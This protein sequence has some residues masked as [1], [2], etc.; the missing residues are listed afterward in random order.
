MAWLKGFAGR[1]EN[2]LNQLDQGAATV[3]NNNHA[4]QRS[5]NSFVGGAAETESESRS[6]EQYITGTR[7]DIVEEKCGLIGGLKQSGRSASQTKTKKDKQAEE[8]QLIKFLN[9]SEDSGVA[10]MEVRGTGH[11]LDWRKENIPRPD[12]NRSF[13]PGGL[14]DLSGSVLMETDSSEPWGDSSCNSGRESSASLEGVP[15]EGLQEDMALN[16][17]HSTDGGCDNLVT[18]KL[19]LATQNQMLRQEISSLTQETSRVLARAKQ[20]EKDVQSLRVS[21]ETE[22]RNTRKQA[23]TIRNLEEKSGRAEITFHQEVEK[24][25]KLINEKDQENLALQGQLSA[26]LA[27]N[28]RHLSQSQEVAGVQSQAILAMEERMRGSEE[29]AREREAMV[30]DERISRR[31]LEINLTEKIKGLEAERQNAKRELISVQK[32]QDDLKNTIGELQQTLATSKAECVDAQKELLEYRAKAQRILLEKENFILQLKEGIC[33]E[34]ED[35]VQ[36]IELQQITKE[37]NLFCEEATRF[38]DQLSSTRRELM[39]MEQ[40]MMTEQEIS[41]ETISQL[42]QQLQS[43]REKREELES[44][45]SRQNEE[46][47]YTRDDLTRAKTSHL[48]AISDKENE[49]KKLRNQINFRHKNGISSGEEDKRIQQLTENLLKKQALVETISSEKNTMMYK[50]EH[51]E[52]QL[53]DASNLKNRKYGLP[54]L[55][56]PVEER[57][58]AFLQE[59]PFDG[60]A[61]RRV[62]RAYTEIDKLSIRVG[63]ALRRFPIARIFVLFY[64]VILHFWV[65]LVLF[66]YTPDTERAM[67]TIP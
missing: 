66:S 42:S 13:S 1:A 7:V 32:K 14:T 57:G 53:S 22:S 28:Q 17:Q 52:R 67:P 36:D 21:L 24:L 43:E 23:E 19:D 20:A 12:S 63:I 27:E 59:S 5:E 54:F 34:S 58:P 25:R 41:R 30:E 37:K 40:E 39:E 49:L 33:N 2:L 31:N 29:L 55:E 48:T 46:L 16:Y 10:G 61:A 18:W 60:A 4:E 65:F 50:I 26:V 56:S 3:L 8:E 64:M 9:G 47:R 44:D 51:L 15:P 45:L 38:S 35:N 6:P 11:P 62:K